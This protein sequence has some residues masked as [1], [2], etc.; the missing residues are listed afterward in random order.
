MEQRMAEHEG[1]GGAVS[2]TLPM[3]SICSYLVRR[4]A[5]S[6]WRKVARH[7]MCGAQPALEKLPF[8]ADG[9]HYRDARLVKYKELVTLGE[10]CP[11]SISTMQSYT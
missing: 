6:W 11:I 9:D 4:D 1:N 3:V 8:A 7:C 10:P 5:K 2:G